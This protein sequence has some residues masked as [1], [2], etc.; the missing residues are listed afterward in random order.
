MF[1]LFTK[2]LWTLSDDLI[3]FFWWDG[4][5]LDACQIW[6]MDLSKY[7][8][9]QWQIDTIPIIPISEIMEPVIKLTWQICQCHVSFDSFRCFCQI[10]LQLSQQYCSIQIC[11]II[12]LMFNLFVKIFSDDL[13]IS[14]CLEVCQFW[15]MDLSKYSDSLTQL[16]C[17]DRWTCL[18]TVTFDTTPMFWQMD[19]LNIVAFDTTPTILSHFVT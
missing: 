17:F 10:L 3:N 6:Q 11:I 8:H 13:I 12:Y 14:F 18:N 16:R 15:Q 7:K 9:W 19:T 1:N 5:K 2:M 4:L